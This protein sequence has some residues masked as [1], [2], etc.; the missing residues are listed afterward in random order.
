M[1]KFKTNFLDRGF[2]QAEGGVYSIQMLLDI[3]SSPSYSHNRIKYL[4]EDMILLGS[5]FLETHR[6]L[7]MGSLAWALSPEERE[8]CFIPVNS[9]GLGKIAHEM[10]NQGR[11]DVLGRTVDV[12][13]G[14]LALAEEDLKDQ[15]AQ[16]VDAVTYYKHALE[17][18]KLGTFIAILVMLGALALFIARPGS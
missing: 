15:K 8:S 13:A 10:H 17:N 9:F 2:I 4:N 5:A 3:V 1:I 14:K 6:L 12:L 7:D 16:E 18:F 11:P